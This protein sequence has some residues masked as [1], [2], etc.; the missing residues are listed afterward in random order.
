MQPE[1]IWYIFGLYFDSYS[2]ETWLRVFGC[3]CASGS[4]KQE[5]TTPIKFL[6]AVCQWLCILSGVTNSRPRIRTIPTVGQVGVSQEACRPENTTHPVKSWPKI[7][8]SAVC[9]NQMFHTQDEEITS[10][11]KL[12]LALSG[13]GFRATLYH[14]G[15]IRLSQRYWDIAGSQ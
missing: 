6:D 12:G 4:D 2:Y 7:E 3:S 14:L 15:V 10:M 8:G 13:G 11:P 9:K 5:K 1:N